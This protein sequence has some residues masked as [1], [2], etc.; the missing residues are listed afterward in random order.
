MYKHLIISSLKEH[1]L[2]VFTVGSYSTIILIIACM[3]NASDIFSVSLISS[4]LNYSIAAVFVICVIA[5]EVKIMF[6]TNRN[7]RLRNDLLLNIR[8][9]YLSKEVIISVLPCLIFI[10]IF[11]STFSSFKTILPIIHKYSMDARLASIDRFLHGGMDPW[12][13]LQPIVGYP[14]ITL[15]LDLCYNLWFGLWITLLIW[16]VFSTKNKFLR[17]RFLLT[18]LLVWTILGTLTATILSST[19][20]CY[21]GRLLD[22]PNLYGKLFDYLHKVDRVY[23]LSALTTQDLLWKIY[24]TDKL[25]L[26]GG[27]SAMPS[28]HVSV[29][30]LL[31][32]LVWGKG[33]LIRFLFLIYFLLIQVGSVHLGWHYAID[34]YV[35]ILG[36][37]GLWI[38]VGWLLRTSKDL[39]YIAEQ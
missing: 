33:R 36:T 17:M 35:S 9:K 23:P 37:F 1:I 39:T 21:Y 34:G 19:G 5:E 25:A 26:G 16:Q 14:P 2:L 24:T 30:F 32:L 4:E 11:F 3:Y 7:G 18:F 8:S 22:S 12:K 29:A 38:F 31:L 15:L 27:I 28:M 13:L 10:P 6:F 20:P